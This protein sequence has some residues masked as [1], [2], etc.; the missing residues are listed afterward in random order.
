V[1]TYAFGYLYVWQFLSEFG[2]SPEEVGINQ[3]KLLT[4]AGLAGLLLEPTVIFLLVPVIY[5]LYSHLRNSGVA[6]EIR[7]ARAWYQSASPIQKGCA[8]ALAVVLSIIILVIV[9]ELPAILA[10]VIIV[11][12]A[13]VVMGKRSLL[14][15]GGSALVL[16]LFF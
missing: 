12:I 9:P 15:A 8:V 16:L 13:V 3:V 6:D 14:I 7:E 5:F 2:V 11:C 10:V 1:L 4:R